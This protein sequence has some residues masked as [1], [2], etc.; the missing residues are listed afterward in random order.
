[1]KVT[2][3]CSK[4][5]EKN[6]NFSF[7]F[8][9]FALFRKVLQM[10][11]NR[12]VLWKVYANKIMDMVYFSSGKSVP[13]RAYFRSNFLGTFVDLIKQWK[14]NTNL[15]VTMNQFFISW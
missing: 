11:I 5:R 12:C 8:V 14:I 7:E 10:L 6:Y 13:S 4:K 9:V 2:L 15:S 1:M 3:I